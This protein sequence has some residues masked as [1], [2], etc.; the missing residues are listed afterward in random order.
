MNGSLEVLFVDNHVLVVAKP[1]GIATA[2]DD[3]GDA[4][5]LDIAKA[6]VKREFHKPGDAFLGLV[7]RLDRPV[8]GVIVFA[9]TSKSASRL[10]EQFRERTVEKRYVAI[11][12]GRVERDEGVLE[13]ALIKDESRNVVRVAR[14]EDPLARF[15]RTRWRV[16]RRANERVVF[17]FEPLTG[18]PHQLRIAAA[19]LGAP[20]AGDLKYGARDPLEDASIALHARSIAFDHPTSRERRTFSADVPGRSIWDVA[21]S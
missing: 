6:W 10:S 9:R 2:P 15:A 20:L 1:A 18:R 13:Q 7:H 5:L 8:S 21:R 16:L 4:S 12:I 3:S 19:T 14:A 11:G 17:E